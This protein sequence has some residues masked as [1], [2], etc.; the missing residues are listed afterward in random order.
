MLASLLAPF[1]TGQYDATVI[2]IA[3]PTAVV[4]ILLP[5]LWG[6]G[7]SVFLSKEE[8][9][10]AGYEPVPDPGTGKQWAIVQVGKQISA[11][12]GFGPGRKTFYEAKLEV[13]FLRH[14][15]AR[16][17]TPFTYKHT[18][19]F[20]SHMM[21][22]SSQ[23]ISGL[24]SSCVNFQVD[25]ETYQVEGSFSVKQSGPTEDLAARS[26]ETWSSEA[27]KRCFEGWFVGENTGQCAT[28]F[29][30]QDLVPPVFKPSLHVRLNLPSLTSL[31]NEAI[32]KLLGTAE[33]ASKMSS[34]EG[35]YDVKGAQGWEL[36]VKTRMKMDKV[37]QV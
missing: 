27:I 21:A 16:T 28:R 1:I 12:V 11:G 15:H 8:L 29:E 37:A 3:L 34:E 5:A 22:L 35:W 14:P 30:T 10:A 32:T 9:K 20:S 18:L 13:P 31:P 17:A 23:H 19:L 2:P 25:D 4:T 24:A 7:G 6:D 33:E 36:S 26:D